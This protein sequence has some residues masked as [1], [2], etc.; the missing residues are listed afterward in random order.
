MGVHE[1]EG[2]AARDGPVVDIQRRRLFLCRRAQ[3]GFGS[4]EQLLGSLFDLGLHDAGPDAPLQGS[5]D[6]FQESLADDEPP[7]QAWCAAA[8]SRTPAVRTGR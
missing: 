6:Y 1:F 2:V 4:R 7:P 8:E 3:S 5:I